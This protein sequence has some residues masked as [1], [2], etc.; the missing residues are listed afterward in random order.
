MPPTHFGIIGANTD[1]GKTLVSAGLL[2]A[3]ARDFDVKVQY[4]KPWQTGTPAS[5]D[6]AFIAN[7]LQSN[8]GITVAIHT[9]TAYNEPVSPHLAARRDGGVKHSDIAVLDSLKQ[10]IAKCDKDEILI[11]EGAGGVASPTP[12]GALQCDVLRLLRCPF[13]LV[14]DF[15]LGGI[16]A[17]VAAFELLQSRGFNV[18]AVVFLADQEGE[19]NARFFAEL[20]GEDRVF[21]IGRGGSLVKLGLSQWLN[22]T[23]ADFS[24]LA[25]HLLKSR[26]QNIDNLAKLAERGN[27]SLW[28]PFTQHGLIEKV[29][30]IESALGDNITFADEGPLFDACGSWWTQSLGHAH[31]ELIGAATSAAGRYGHVM[32]PGNAHAPAVALTEAMLS[33]VGAGW[34]ERVFFSDNGSTAVEVA[35]KVAFRLRSARLTFSG[36]TPPFAPLKVIGLRDSYHGDTI[37]AMDAASPNTFNAREPWYQG[38][39]V[40]APFPTIGIEGGHWAVSCGLEFS[41]WVGTELPQQCFAD[42]NEIFSELR[43]T[44]PL[45]QCY[46]TA[47]RKWLNSLACSEVAIGA[48]LLEPIVQG[49]GGMMFVDPLFQRV[50]IDEA[51]AIGVPVVFDEVFSGFWR[52]GYL[53]AADVLG[54]Y[55]DIA[56]Y[57]KSLTGGLVPLGTTLVTNEAFDCFSGN[58]KAQALLHG[59]SFTGYPIGC[60]VAAK[61]ITIMENTTW[62]K[63]HAHA[64]SLNP[65]LPFCVFEDDAILK[66]TSISGVNAAWSCGTVFA[67]SLS[68]N[69]EVHD[70][71]TSSQRISD[72]INHLRRNGVYARN[73]GNVLYGM[74]SLTTT[75]EKAQWL[76]D[77]YVDAVSSF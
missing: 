47:I 57:S 52:L 24:L 62:V 65:A 69:N 35:L 38:R 43:L 45:A 68:T 73:L 44:S 20:I 36:N 46:T 66:L 2:A 18:G 55:P 60:A 25:N 28:W 27:S 75:A 7:N 56:C 53:R 40:W 29:G 13:V 67:V 76:I 14:G 34:A 5:Y 26:Q 50:L 1:V 70:Y 74:T 30:V 49:A 23:T 8:W 37:G 39:G 9:I 12:E 63:N 64:R 4:V 6:A 19:E 77:R 72:T 58:D 11:F 51:R 54:V 71:N 31:P 61:A 15:K 33:G 10:K 48:L 32:F 41:E 59:H 3:F 21:T 22:S 42:R 16:T 17:T